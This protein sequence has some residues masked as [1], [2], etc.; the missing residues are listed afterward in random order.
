MGARKRKV[1]SPPTKAIEWW[2]GP[3]GRSLAG[4]KLHEA[5]PILPMWC[6]LLVYTE[7]V[8]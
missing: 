6:I 3:D 4:T 8:P 7:V 1:L 5:A 2:P